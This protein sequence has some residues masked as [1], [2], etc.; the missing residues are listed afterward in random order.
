MP[1]NTLDHKFP[2][3]PT[4]SHNRR[5]EKTESKMLMGS[6]A[7]RQPRMPFSPSVV[8]KCCPKDWI[9]NKTHK[10]RRNTNIS[11]MDC[12]AEH[13][14][15]MSCIFVISQNKGSKADQSLQFCPRSLPS[16][17]RCEGRKW[18]HFLLLDQ[19]PG[20]ISVFQSTRRHVHLPSRG[21]L[22]GG[23]SYFPEQCVTGGTFRP[24]LLLNK[25]PERLHCRFQE[26]GGP[27][28]LPN[29]GKAVV[30]PAA[31]DQERWHHH[32]LEIH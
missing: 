1:T 13:M 9:H 18:L 32:R 12:V 8:A 7:T 21:S 28:N 30:Y 11:V 5:E 14:G 25:T 23:R 27:C 2:F 20:L 24:R 15:K 10:T 22:S 19:L 6:G 17:L 3:W 29:S 4:A 26:V 31:T 16:T